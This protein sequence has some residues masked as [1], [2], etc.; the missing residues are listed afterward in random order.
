M[1]SLFVMI[2]YNVS[3]V[4]QFHLLSGTPFFVCQTEGNRTCNAKLQ[5]VNMSGVQRFINQAFLYQKCQTYCIIFMPFSFLGNTLRMFKVC[6]K[7]ETL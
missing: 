6:G 5:T 3:C 2:E 7:E 4:S 1:C